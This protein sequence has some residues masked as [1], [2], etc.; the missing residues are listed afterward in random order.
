MPIR[1]YAADWRDFTTWCSSAGLDPLPAAA[2]TVALYLTSLAGVLKASTL[3]RRLSSIS[4]AHQ[5]AG[6]DTPTRNPMVA[7]V[8]AGIRRTHGTAQDGKSPTLIEDLRAMVAA[9]APRRGQAWRLLDLRDRALLLLGFAGAFRRSELVSLDVD[10]LEF[11]RAGVAVRLRRSKTDQE[12]QGR[13]IGIPRGQQAATCPVAALQTYLKRAGIEEGPIFRGMNRHDQLTAGTAAQRSRCGGGGEAAI[14]GGRTEPPALCR[15]QSARW[16]GDFGRGRRSDRAE[17]HG[18]NRSPLGHN[19]AALYPG[20]R[21]VPP[22]QRCN[23]GRPVIVVQF[24]HVRTPYM[25][26]RHGV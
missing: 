26:A 10:D 6:L 12:G 3:Q 14:S 8:W 17:H 20:R 15:S 25:R 5:V 7:L 21:A 13:R 9:M 1:A 23:S 18:A 22:R 16:T 4:Q 11:S 19:G 24:A 2:T